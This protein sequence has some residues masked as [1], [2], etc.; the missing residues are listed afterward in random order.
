M[1]YK[2][3]NRLS[4]LPPSPKH[5]FTETIHP[6]A[7]YP[8]GKQN[9]R[10]MHKSA[11][12]RAAAAACWYMRNSTP[13]RL[14]V[15]TLLT[16]DEGV[17]LEIDA[18]HARAREI[19][20]PARSREK[21]RRLSSLCFHSAPENN[22]IQERIIRGRINQGSPGDIILVVKVVMVSFGRF[23]FFFFCVFF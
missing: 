11:P 7:L 4:S 21:W 9:F 14:R 17:P 22:T 3:N 5:Y 15:K 12:L 13:A 16:S 20:C 23:R 18:F 19:N 10:P 8:R 1:P 2:S 6:P